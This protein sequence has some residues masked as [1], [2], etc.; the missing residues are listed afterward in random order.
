ML[1][2][3]TARTGNIQSALT[4]SVNYRKTRNRLIF[5]LDCKT[6]NQL[7]VSDIIRRT[8]GENRERE[9]WIITRF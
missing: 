9:E 8:D 3:T 6:V 7:R 2:L 4:A 1:S 5:P